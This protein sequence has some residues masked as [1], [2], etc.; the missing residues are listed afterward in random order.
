MNE[1][2]DC[3]IEE[4][5]DD[6]TVPTVEPEV[7]EQPTVNWKQKLTSRKLWTA[8][9][10]VVVGLAATFGLKE[11]DWAQIAGIV[12]SAASVVAYIFGESKIDAA[13][14]E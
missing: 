10:G 3:V 12:T 5:Y 9:V 11:N 4:E 2:F 13:R 14:K 8:V 6:T 1:E 7:I